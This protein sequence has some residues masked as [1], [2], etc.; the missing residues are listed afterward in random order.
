MPETLS[1]PNALDTV[2]RKAAAARETAV[3]KYRELLIS[4]GARPDALA[5]V[6][7]AIGKTPADAAADQQAIQRA[8]SLQKTIDAGRGLGA[9]VE[10]SIKAIEQHRTET[11]A[12]RQ[13]RDAELQQLM[14]DQKALTD[15]AGAAEVAKTS[16][17]A[18]K[19]SHPDVFST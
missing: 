10:A 3:G 9:E 17:A 2:T 19:R 18:L 15:R 1:P 6:M 5:D 4:D 11:V 8:R 13:K 14:I 7:G 16:L 12:M